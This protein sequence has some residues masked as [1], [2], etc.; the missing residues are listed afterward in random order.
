M[1]REISRKRKVRD[2]CKA[3]GLRFQVGRFQK[4]YRYCISYV[5]ELGSREMFCGNLNECLAAI[6]TMVRLR[7]EDTAGGQPV[8]AMD[9]WLSRI[10]AYLEALQVNL[11]TTRQQRGVF[12]ALCRTK[13]G[14]DCFLQPDK[15]PE[16]NK[17]LRA[18]DRKLE[19]TSNQVLQIRQYFE[20]VNGLA[21]QLWDHQVAT[22]ISDTMLDDIRMKFNPQNN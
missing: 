6:D 3:H 14:E 4:N 1:T 21:K 9:N 12:Y 18:Y 22:T 5:V 17:I 7:K 13:Y 8:G 16:E 15:Q 19:T 10:Q 11:D 2:L 20:Q